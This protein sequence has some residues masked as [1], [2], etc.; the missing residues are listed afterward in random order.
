MLTIFSW[1]GYTFLTE[2]PA[3]NSVVSYADGYDTM[4]WATDD[5]I[6]DIPE[7]AAYLVIYY[8]E[9][10]TDT[11]KHYYPDAIIFGKND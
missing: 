11:S 8:Q 9:S 10:Y 1:I 7:D 4:E 5:V 6:L 2:L 3:V